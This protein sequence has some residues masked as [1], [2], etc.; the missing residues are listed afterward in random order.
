MFPCGRR[1]GASV[2]FIYFVHRAESQRT[3]CLPATVSHPAG[4]QVAKYTLFLLVR[5]AH[6]IV[7]FLPPAKQIADIVM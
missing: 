3:S 6:S 1:S 4:A 7:A 5:F 2:V